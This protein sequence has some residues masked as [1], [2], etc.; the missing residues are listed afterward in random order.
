MKRT[1]AILVSAGIALSL[2]ACGGKA[3]QTSGASETQ[4]A[5]T[6]SQTAANPL[7]SVISKAQADFSDTA[8]KLLDEQ[9]KMFGEVGD[10]YE[11]YLQNIDKVQAWYDLAVDETEQLG[12]RAVEY[13]D[14][15]PV[16]EAH[17]NGDTLPVVERQRRLA[18]LCLGHPVRQRTRGGYLHQHGEC[19]MRLFEL[20]AA[21]YYDSVDARHTVSCISP[22]REACSQRWRQRGLLRS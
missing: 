18:P 6:E 5:G 3:P 14:V 22:Y 9:Q 13:G 12:A 10:T 15:K 17:G 16:L 19:R 20:G 4:A 7:E 21:N 8:Q 11:G 2:A 1:L